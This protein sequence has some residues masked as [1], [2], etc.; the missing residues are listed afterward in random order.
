MSAVISDC[1]KYRYQL[2]RALPS[3]PRDGLSTLFVML[4]PSTADAH[5]DDPTIRRCMGFANRFGSVSLVVANLYGLRATD[6]TGLWR[7]ED[8]VGPNNDHWLTYLLQ[9]HR[10]AICAWGANAR[11]DRVIKFCEMA[12]EAGAKLWCLGTTKDGSPRHPLYLRKD[13]KMQEWPPVNN[14]TDKQY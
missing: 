2:S 11:S 8:P 5:Q 4:N 3:R 13:A 7:V 6:P 1:G 12:E 10:S 14:P 9:N